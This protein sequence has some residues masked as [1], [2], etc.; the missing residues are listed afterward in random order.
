[1]NINLSGNAKAYACLI[2]G[3]ILA[4]FALFWSFSAHKGNVERKEQKRLLA[5]SKKNQ[6]C[7]GFLESNG[8]ELKIIAVQNNGYVAVEG[9]DGER[10]LVRQNGKICLV[11]DVWRADVDLLHGNLYLTERIR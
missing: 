6:E 2:L 4:S 5:L 8:S 11:G 10:R 1:M 9:S 7:I 3:I